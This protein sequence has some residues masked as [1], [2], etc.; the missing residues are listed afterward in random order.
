[1]AYIEWRKDYNL[2]I[3]VIDKQH[4][5]IA[6][7]INRMHESIENGDHNS[8]EELFDELIDYTMTHFTFEEEILER[9]GYE[10]SSAHQRVH[11]VFIKKIT[12]YKRQFEE[13]NTD[14]A[15]RVLQMLR[16]WLI[17]HIQHDD[18]DYVP[19]VMFMMQIKPGKRGWINRVLG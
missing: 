7:Y 16:N 10:F 12:E 8:I 1:M 13:G 9:A 6:E 11:K 3:D 15:Y 19:A 18:A 17:N 4:L 2:G 14:I 5:R